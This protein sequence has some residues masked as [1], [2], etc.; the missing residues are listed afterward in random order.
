M[1]QVIFLKSY[2]HRKKSVLAKNLI[3]SILLGN[4]THLVYSV[5]NQKYPNSNDIPSGSIDLIQQK[6]L[7]IANEAIPSVNI[8]NDNEVNLSPSFNVNTERLRHLRD[9]N[10]DNTQLDG[11]SDNIQRGIQDTTLSYDNS[12][13][14]SHK[15][16]YFNTS[17]NKH[18]NRYSKNVFL[19]IQ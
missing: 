7:P 10:D 16:S 17:I 4:L 12:L 5:E 8:D 19:I 14:T 9:A 11:A 15:S 3:L 2:A 1:E 6:T 18:S 13:A